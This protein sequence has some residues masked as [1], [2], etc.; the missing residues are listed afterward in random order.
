[1]DSAPNRPLI[2]EQKE[3]LPIAL[4]VII[5]TY[6]HYQLF[7]NLQGRCF[8]SLKKSHNTISM[9]PG[10][11]SFS[12]QTIPKWMGI[13]SVPMLSSA[14]RNDQLTHALTATIAKSGQGSIHY[15]VGAQTQL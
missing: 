7:K 6:T 1:M 12:W 11:V 4:A 15:L 14:W 2:D 5:Q 10:G 8:I 9:V 13:R 3:S